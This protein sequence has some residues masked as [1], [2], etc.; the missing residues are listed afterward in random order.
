MTLKK[1]QSTLGEIIKMETKVSFLCHVGKPRKSERAQAGINWEDI[2]P[3][4]FEIKS[5]I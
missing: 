2:E 3:S 1:G 5:D 4:C